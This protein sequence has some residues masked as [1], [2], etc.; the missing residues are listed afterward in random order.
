MTDADGN[1]I[2]KDETNR[3]VENKDGSA[4]LEASWLAQKKRKL[5]KGLGRLLNWCNKMDNGEAGVISETL[6]H[7]LADASAKA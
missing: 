6:Y 1:I 3:G 2:L 5:R 7:V 4:S